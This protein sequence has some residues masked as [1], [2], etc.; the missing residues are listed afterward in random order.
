MAMLGAILGHPYFR[1]CYSL[2]EIGF[3]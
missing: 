2:L 1:H 3:L